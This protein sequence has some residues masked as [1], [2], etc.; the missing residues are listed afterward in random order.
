MR[1]S[2]VKTAVIFVYSH[3]FFFFLRIWL[4]PKRSERRYRVSQRVR[5]L[6]VA[7]QL[8]RILYVVVYVSANFV[9]QNEQVK[10]RCCLLLHVKSN[11]I[12]LSHTS[13]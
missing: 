12:R 1:I 5:Q 2:E 11:Y 4:Q 7:F 3:R 8:I 9:Q 10:K 6:I 13:Q